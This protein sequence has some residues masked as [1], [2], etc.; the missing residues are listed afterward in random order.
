MARAT[1][2]HICPRGG[3]TNIHLIPRWVGAQVDG[4]CT[5]IDA[6]GLSDRKVLLK[7]D[8]EGSECDAL[9]GAEKTLLENPMVRVIACSYHRAQDAERISSFLLE[10]HFRVRYSDGVMFFPYGESIE[11]TFRHGLVF[12]DKTD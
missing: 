12:G 1:E 10:R 11:P 4:Q 2:T 8:I 7:M 6:L 5:T 3:G 9:A